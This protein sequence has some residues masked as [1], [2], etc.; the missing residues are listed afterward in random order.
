MLQR[1]APQPTNCVPM[2][3]CSSLHVIQFVE[4]EAKL[5]AVV[6]RHTGSDGTISWVGV[7]ADMPGRTDNQV[8]RHWKTQQKD[9]RCAAIPRRE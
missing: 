2:T 8:M 9:S 5:R 6:E 4:E 7:A 1:L 3:H